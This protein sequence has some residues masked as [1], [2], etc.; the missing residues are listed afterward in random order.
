M[1]TEYKLWFEP[2][3]KITIA[4]SRRSG[5]HLIN[6]SVGQYNAKVVDS[7]ESNIALDLT[8][9]KGVA[10]SARM[11]IDLSPASKSDS[12]VQS[13]MKE[14]DANVS[15]LARRN[16]VGSTIS[17]VG[18]VLQLAKDIMDNVAHVHPIVKAV[19][20]VL[21]RVYEVS[22]MV[23]CSVPEY[24]NASLGCPEN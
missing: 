10:I 11:R 13:F 20:T 23:E 12:D 22:H 24:D 16:A 9:K 8:D 2:S 18:K 6:Y 1:K 7:L 5:T 4:F 14:V 21:S 19:W 3:S 15:N 17:T